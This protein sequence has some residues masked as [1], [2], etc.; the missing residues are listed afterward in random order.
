MVKSSLLINLYIGIFDRSGL[1]N[2]AVLKTIANI[3]AFVVGVTSFPSS[4]FVTT[5]LLGIGEG[6]VP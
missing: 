2:K 3:I 1:T 6:F 4:T 5:A